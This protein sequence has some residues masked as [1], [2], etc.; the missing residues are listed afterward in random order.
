MHREAGR[1]DEMFVAWYGRASAVGETEAL[2]RAVSML[3]R[4]DDTR[5]P[6]N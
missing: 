3:V 5:A 6:T 1:F 2:S 4:Q